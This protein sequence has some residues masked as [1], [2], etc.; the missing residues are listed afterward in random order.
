MANLFA[1]II[2]VEAMSCLTE[3]L[4]KCD[5]L[6]YDTQERR[7]THNLQVSDTLSSFKTG[8]LQV[9]TEWA[10]VLRTQES[11]NPCTFKQTSQHLQR[12]NARV[13]SN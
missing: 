1:R 7:S 12:R 11:R 5:N 8:Y 2:P 10:S 9:F 4:G 3:L 13:P 6:Q